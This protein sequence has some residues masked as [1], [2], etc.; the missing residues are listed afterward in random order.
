MGG[1]VF[2][3]IWSYLLLTPSVAATLSNTVVFLFCFLIN[4]T[5]WFIFILQTRLH[6]SSRLRLAS[7]ATVNTRPRTSGRWEPV[8]RHGHSAPPR[9]E[10]GL[11]QCQ[12]DSSRA[13]LAAVCQRDPVDPVS[14]GGVCGQCVGVLQRGYR[15]HIHVLF[16][17]LHFAVRSLTILS[18]PF[19]I[20]W[21]VWVISLK[22]F[23]VMKISIIYPGR[24]VR[25]IGMVKWRRP[26]LLAFLSSFSAETWPTLQAATSP[27]SCPF[28]WTCSDI[29]CVTAQPEKT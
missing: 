29:Q 21:N 19:L 4:V 23:V 13:G 2:W 10:C 3:N 28:R 9:Q 8:S 18:L 26:C 11:A 14:A 25:P 27:D 16:S 5:V 17:A 6:A 1:S 7:V 15:T 20:K 22:V 24:S 12:L